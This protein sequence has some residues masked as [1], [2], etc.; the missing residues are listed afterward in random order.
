MAK[1]PKQSII[2]MGQT[3]GGGWVEIRKPIVTPPEAPKK[4]IPRQQ[5]QV[6]LVVSKH[7]PNGEWRE[8]S[9]KAV[10]KI[11]GEDFKSRGLGDPPSYE[12]VARALG[13]K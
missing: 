3:R 13:R 2:F 8:L 9:I 10:W 7:W 4:R 11:V 1:A 6:Q 12:T 5:K